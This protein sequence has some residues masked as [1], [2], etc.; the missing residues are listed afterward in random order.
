MKLGGLLGLVCLAA[1]C[2]GGSSTPDAA[3][4]DGA[5][6]PPDAQANCNTVYLA[7]DQIDLHVGA[8]DATVSSS[9]II[10]ADA[11]APGYRL[12]AADR[13]T[14]IAA[15]T[16]QIVNTLSPL[17]ID[18]LSIRPASGDY[19][20]IVIG[21]SST[22]VGLQAGLGGVSSFAGCDQPVPKRITYAFDTVNGVHQPEIGVAN[23][24]IGSFLVGLGTPTSSDAADCLCWDAPGCG[25]AVAAACT[26]GGATT[27]RY[28]SSVCGTGTTFDEPAV[29]AAGLDAITCP[30]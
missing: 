1:A 20:M 24:A 7:F 3:V 10:P 18:V 6:P 25:G 8:E 23:I 9:S 16:D 5:P 30:P 28:D 21:G 27:P 12:D 29:I 15:I 17:G 11:T 4:P 19:T 13:E 26:I 22:D 2:G 14:Q